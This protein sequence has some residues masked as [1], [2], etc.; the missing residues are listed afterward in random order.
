MPL[1]APSIA[2]SNAA[3]QNHCEAMASNETTS[4][5]LAPAPGAG[6]QHWHPVSATRAQPSTSTRHRH[7]NLHH[8]HNERQHPAPA[9]S[10]STHPTPPSTH[11]VRPPQLQPGLSAG[12]RETTRHKHQRRQPVSTTSQLTAPAPATCLHRAHSLT[13]AVNVA[14]QDAARE[15]KKGKGKRYPAPTSEPSEGEGD[16]MK[17]IGPDNPKWEQ[18]RKIEAA[19]IRC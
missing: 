3:Q 9:S 17:I 18:L 15:A 14:T 11:F 6:S 5:L 13:R 7:H 10:S 16:P 1:P 19:D 2:K 8:A 4:E 12:S